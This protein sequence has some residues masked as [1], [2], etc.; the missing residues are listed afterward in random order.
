MHAINPRC[1]LVS[2]LKRGISILRRSAGGLKKF[3]VFN[4]TVILL[5]TL[6]IR[7]LMIST[8]SL[9]FFRFRIKIW[10]LKNFLKVIKISR[11]IYASET[12]CSTV[13]HKAS[14]SYLQCNIAHTLV[15]IM[16]PY[17]PLRGYI[18]ADLQY[19]FQETNALCK[20]ENVF[21]HFRFNAFAY[22][23]VSILHKLWS[24]AMV[25]VTL[26]TS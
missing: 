18:Y 16:L 2:S 10:L 20:N 11:F 23:I 8:Y 25:D 21:W 3:T 9:V 4:I 6:H 17:L 1:A 5:G 15:Y 19:W 24:K 7:L 13:H 14:R 22:W 12:T 26:S